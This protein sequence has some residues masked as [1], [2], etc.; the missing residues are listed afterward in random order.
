MTMPTLF[1]LILLWLDKS[2]LV[3]NSPWR[4]KQKTRI[5]VFG[6]K[7]CCK[8]HLVKETEEIFWSEY[9]P[10]EQ[11]EKRALIESQRKLKELCP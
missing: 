8:R 11:P 3:E 9:V 7:F 2:S 10:Y 5:W 1:L 6:V 4:E